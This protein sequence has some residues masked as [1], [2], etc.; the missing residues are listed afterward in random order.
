MHCGFAA[1]SVGS[2]R[3]KNA[4]EILMKVLLD[5]CFAA[6]GWWAT[7]YALAFG[8]GP[9][10][11]AFIGETGFFMTQMNNS[12]YH[13]WFFQ[14]SENG[15]KGNGQEF[16]AVP[17]T[18]GAASAFAPFALPSLLL[19]SYIF[20]TANQHHFPACHTVFSLRCFCR[21][22]HPA[23][24]SLSRITPPAAVRL[25]RHRRDRH[26]RVCGGALPD[27]GLCGLLATNNDVG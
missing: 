4:K 24:S 19:P 9:V 5:A 10:S 27:D 26:Q 13:I 14:V 18:A 22:L 1:L 15:A 6:L 17:P 16:G 23:L 8:G 20:S 12:N 2:V 21:I 7:G 3:G 11:N 25:R